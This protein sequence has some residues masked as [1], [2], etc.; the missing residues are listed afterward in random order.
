MQNIVGIS[1]VCITL[2]AYQTAAIATSDVVKGNC[3]DQTPLPQPVPMNQPSEDVPNEISR[4]FGVWSNGKWNEKLCTTLAV[5]SVDAAGNAKAIYSY[6]TYA[7][8]NIQQPN[9][10]ETSGEI[11][12]D[13]LRLETFGNGADVS[14]WFSD[15]KLKGTYTRNDNTSYVTLTKIKASN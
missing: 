7:G 14:Y 4:F 11:T 13:R 2:A 15:G 5:T 8:W 1:V 12:N 10:F 6:G 3:I 9:Q